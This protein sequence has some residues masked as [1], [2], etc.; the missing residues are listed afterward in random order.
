MNIAKRT[1][2]E[3]IISIW[4]L[5]LIVALGGC[6]FVDNPLAYLLGELVGS[7]TATILYINLYLSIDLELDLPKDKAIRHSRSMGMIRTF[8]EVGVL[9][10][11]FFL[12]DYVLP[13]T[14]FAGLIARKFSAL[15]VPFIDWIYK[16]FISKEPYEKPDYS[17][18]EYNNEYD[19]NI[20][21]DKE[22]ELRLQERIEKKKEKIRIIEEEKEANKE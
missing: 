14:V 16:R 11:S 12:Q 22:F 20:K 6:F 21:I 5:A 15:M 17:D 19:D 18:Y 9:V 8:V 13:Y 1:L 3:A 7:L 10:A 2:I 4:I